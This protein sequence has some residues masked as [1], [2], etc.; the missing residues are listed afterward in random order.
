M[1]LLLGPWR[2]SDREG[3]GGG[4]RPGPLGGWCLGG[5]AVSRRGLYAASLASLGVP[6]E[7]H[8]L[9]PEAVA[10]DERLTTMPRPVARHALRAAACGRACSSGSEEASEL[11]WAGRRVGQIWSPSGVCGAEAARGERGFLGRGEGE[12]GD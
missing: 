7:Q 3:G 1:V 9:H 4:S 2:R 5:G 11:Q 6:G 8:G 10:V 12:E